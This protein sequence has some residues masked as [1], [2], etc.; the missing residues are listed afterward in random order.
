[1]SNWVAI[2]IALALAFVISA[3]SGKWII[4]W[5]HKLKYGQTILD[6][7]PSW[8]KKK[9]GTPTMG[10]IMFII[11]SVLSIIITILIFTLTKGDMSDG[12]NNYGTNSKVLVYAGVILA[13]GQG[14]VGFADDYISV[15]KKKN[16]GLTPKQKT[17]GL[18][19]ID[20][21]YL[22]ALY[23]SK[24]TWFY[25]PFSSK[26]MVV[27]LGGSVWGGIV[28]W[29]GG[30]FLI[31]RFANA[32]NLTDGI[33]GLCGSVT[34][35]VAVAM[36]IISVLHKF[37]G[38]SIFAAAI[39]GACAG[40]LI[41]NHYPAKVFMGDTGSLFLGGAVIALAFALHIPYILLII[42]IVYVC[43]TGSVM[44][45]VSYYKLTKK[46]Y[47][48]KDENGNLVGRRIFKM[49]PIHHHFELSGWKENK[50][51]TVFSLVSVIAAVI[52]I[53]I[54]YFGIFSRLN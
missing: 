33:D 46:I 53:A 12:I 5:L 43:E 16:E 39:A 3:V 50:I 37:A 24:N 6:I 20:F 38:V 31:Y 25:L 29:L 22:L 34:T 4:P 21:G 49:T 36:L 51:V 9:Q 52:G 18:V 32:V 48:D 17:L 40:Y 44:L 15:V 27:E 23:L 14:I 30:I 19:L 54:V 10:G 11:A 1:M 7:G 26:H 45:Q 28:F 41:W 42:G 2:A 13:L 35:V 8:H 47:K